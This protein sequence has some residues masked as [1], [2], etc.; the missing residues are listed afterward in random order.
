MIQVIEFHKTYGE[1]VAVAG[2]TFEVLPGQIVGLL[3][4]NG[5][6]KTTTMRAI[7]GIIPPTRGRLLVAGHDVSVDPVAA[8]RQL[9]Y[10]PAD[11]KPFDTLTVWQPPAC[12]ASPH[13]VR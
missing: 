4:P 13:P 1:T 7:S 9:A 11:P 5:A 10:V 3:G 2:L 12:T 8:K 6:G